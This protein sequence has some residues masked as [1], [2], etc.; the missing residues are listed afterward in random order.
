MDGDKLWDFKII[1]VLV[2]SVVSPGV[3]GARQ[4]T[5]LKRR[6]M[7]EESIVASLLSLRDA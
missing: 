5:I 1:L 3:L 7:R 4:N 2:G 6:Q